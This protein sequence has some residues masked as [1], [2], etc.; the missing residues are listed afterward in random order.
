MRQT[1]AS[2]TGLL[3]S[4]IFRLTLLYLCLFTAAMLALVGFIYWLATDSVTRQIDKTIDA[5]IRGLAEQYRQRGTVGLIQVIRQRTEGAGAARGLYLLTDQR[6]L[7]L[8][9]NLSRWPDAAPDPDGWI[10]FPLEFPDSEGG[11]NFGRGRVFELSG[12]LHLLVGHDLRERT[13]I[14]AVIRETLAWGLIAVV[15]LSLAGGLLMSRSLLSRIDRVNATARDIM[16]GDLSRR[17]PTSGRDD[18]FDRLAGNLNAMLDRIERLLAGMKQ[19]SDNIAHDLRSP[20]TRL[21]SR[22]EVTLMERHDEAAY[23]QA[24]EQTIAEADGLLKTFNALL[25]IAQAESGAPRQGFAP[26]ELGALVG[27]VAELYEPL[28]EDRGLTLELGEVAPMTIA[29]DRHLLFQGLVNL[30]D[31]AIKFSPSGGRIA[32]SLTRSGERA[33]L[34]VADSGPGIP[35]AARAQVLDRFVRLESSRS[36]PGS[37]LSLAAAVARLHDGELRLEDNAPEDNTPGLRASLLLPLGGQMQMSAA[38]ER[39]SNQKEKRLGPALGV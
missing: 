27:D 36:T 25:S 11:L 24:I 6:F 33:C 19:V 10:T 22:L 5:E 7:P 29:G 16:A 2:Q 37:G 4:R 32:L 8:A 17:V 21:R 39:A 1:D 28:A 26:V 3:H 12:G 38:A 23:R 18:E 34:T 13:R 31:N 20:L 14:A 9:G 15:G 30:L 35:E